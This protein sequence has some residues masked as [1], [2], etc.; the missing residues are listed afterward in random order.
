MMVCRSGS[1]D[2]ASRGRRT[3][4]CRAP[5]FLA[6]LALCAASGA[7]YSDAFVLRDDLQRDVTFHR[8]PL[9]IITMLPSMT[10]T[11]CALG[12]CDRLVAT[13]RYSGWPAQVR[14]LPKTGGLVDPAIEL[15]VS[16]KPDLVLVY[17]MPDAASLELVRLGSHSELSL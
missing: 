11:V 2:R 5:A 10:E 16:L 12:A 3:T 14:A 13:D 1:C 7:A 15:I 8:S 17:R 9:R 6:I 4:R